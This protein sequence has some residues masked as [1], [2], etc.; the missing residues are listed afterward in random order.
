MS[1]AAGVGSQDPS[2]LPVGRRVAYWRVRRGM[3]Q[4]ML[5]DRLDRS[6][7]W[8][9]K[10]ER[11]VRRLDRVSVLHEIA[12]VL[13][14]P[15][16]QLL[17]GAGDAERAG[18]G[19]GVGGVEGVR[20][21]LARYTSI[22]AYL[23]AEVTPPDLAELGKAVNH[24]WL[25]FQHGGHDRLVRML[26]A[27][28]A[29]AQ[30]A[31]GHHRGGEG[32]GRAA[33]LLGQV[34]QVASSV[35]RKL[36]EGEL[37]WFA[38][39]RAAAVSIRADDPLLV[40]LAA[41]RA[42]NALLAL[43]RP[44]AALEA[45]VTAA[46]RLAPA[47]AG[48]ATPQRL[49]VYGSL[50]LQGAMAAAHLGDHSGV[51]DLVR[52][53]GHVAAALGGDRNDYWTSFGPTNLRLHVVAASVELG[54]AGD[55]IEA[56]EGLDPAGFGALVPERRAQHLLDLA[57]AHNLANR[58]DRAVA[59]L[60]AAERLAPAEVRHRPVAHA[61]LRD[62]ARRVRGKLPGPLA[63]LARRARIDPL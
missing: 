26:P 57:R 60:L 14:I 22:A 35:L 40:G 15:V 3:T 28:L 29:D 61:A 17:R 7:S 27:L 45:Q 6:K 31:D 8:L 20:A 19:A 55:A 11:G 63:D 42:G 34:Y 62:A 12:R 37:A 23:G 56:A 58:P 10:V 5:A 54:E 49:S 36:G 46:N 53:A 25:S 38:A 13:E 9:D 24:A 59:L 16:D 41:S 48:E 51:A 44:R 47:D 33:H 32:A 4:Q 21:A 2:E 52:E 39:D 50:L 30:A 43:D 18:R 1:D